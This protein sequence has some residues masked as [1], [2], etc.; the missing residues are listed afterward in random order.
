MNIFRCFNIN[1][2]IRFNTCGVKSKFIL[3]AFIILLVVFG[4]NSVLIADDEDKI[5]IRGYGDIIYSHYNFGPDQRS[6]ENGSPADSRAILD[7]VRFVLELSYAFDP[8]LQFETEIEF[9]HGG[10]GG[11]M[12]LEY[13][14]FG[15]YE[16]EI[17]KGGEVVC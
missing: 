15:E 2:F 13:E 10:T 1:R 6:G 14:E 5:H 9:E 3:Q 12:E 7:L 11:T 4:M 17:E 16:I 8:T